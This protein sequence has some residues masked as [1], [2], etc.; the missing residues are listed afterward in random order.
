MQTECLDSKA[1][2]GHHQDMRVFIFSLCFM[3]A[4]CSVQSPETVE[5]EMNHPVII[6]ETSAG[7][8]EITVYPDKAPISAGDFLRHVDGKLYDGQGFYRTVHAQN[9]PLNMGMSLIQGGRL[10]KEIIFGPIAHELTTNTGISNA[11]G[12][13]AIARLEPGS[14]SAA[15]F[16]IN[17]GNNDFLDTGGPR[18]PDGQG[19]ATFG[20]VTKGLEVARKIQKMETD[21]SSDDPVT[22][23][24][25]LKTPVIIT[26]AYRK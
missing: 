13:V 15:Y 21:A 22:Q 19:Y 23:G 14:G 18:N 5:A 12:A 7:P 3:V 11:D 24:Q 4:G 1:Q 2:T 26:R 16:F 6:L 8:M 9:D 10:D 25:T 20:R 17:I